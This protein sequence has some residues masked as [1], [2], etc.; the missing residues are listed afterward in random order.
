MRGQKPSQGT[1][2]SYKHLNSLG[3]IDRGV[4]RGESPMVLDPMLQSTQ[5]YQ[6]IV[7]YVD[8]FDYD[9]PILY[10]QILSG[11]SFTHSLQI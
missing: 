4:D 5:S 10:A 11:Y 1:Y 2:P 6:S 3:R 9:L 8:K 7:Y